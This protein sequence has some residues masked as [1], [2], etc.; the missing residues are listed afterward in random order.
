MGKFEKCWD[1]SESQKELNS[2]AY[3]LPPHLPL[4]LNSKHFS[5]YMN[6]SCSGRVILTHEHIQC[7]TGSPSWKYVKQS[8][9]IQVTRNFILFF[10]LLIWVNLIRSID[11]RVK[12]CFRALEIFIFNMMRFHCH[13]RLSWYLKVTLILI[14]LRK[15]KMQLC[16][17][18]NRFV[19]YLL[20]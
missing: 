6:Y 12:L 5:W 19:T 4:L 15:K 10:F 9:G 16:E 18:I 2:W 13:H 3:L 7:I 8:I 14:S 11:R 17:W 1:P 20:K